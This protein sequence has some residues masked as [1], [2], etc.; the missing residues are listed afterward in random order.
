M[1][2]G[3]RLNSLR[4]KKNLAEMGEILGVSAQQLSRIENDKSVPSLELILR[5]CEHFGVTMD[6]LIRGVEP[7]SL[8][9]PSAPKPGYVTIPA[10]ELIELQ[11]IALGKKDQALKEQERQIDQLKNDE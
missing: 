3:Q 1:T 10:E 9:A 11:R 5:I 8:S 6:W 7:E 2:I 4:G